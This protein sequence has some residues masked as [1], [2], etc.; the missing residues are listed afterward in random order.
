M[1]RRG[2]TEEGMYLDS[3]LPYEVLLRSPLPAAQEGAGG[4]VTGGGSENG[5]GEELSTLSVPTSAGWYR[6]GANT[7]RKG[8]AKF[9]KCFIYQFVANTY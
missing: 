7:Y 1:H 2:G 9:F 6:T 5:R 3:W 4:W 8:I